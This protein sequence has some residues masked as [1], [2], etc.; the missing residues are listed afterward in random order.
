MK[1]SFRWK[2]LFV[3]L[4][5]VS[6]IVFCTSLLADG[7]VGVKIF[8][9]KKDRST[10]LKSDIEQVVDAVEKSFCN[11]GFNCLDRGAG[12][13]AMLEEVKLGQQGVLNEAIKLGKARQAQFAL[14]VIVDRLSS[15]SF[16]LTT[17]LIHLESAQIIPIS[18]S[19]RKP[20]IDELFDYASNTLGRVV[21]VQRKTE[22]LRVENKLSLYYFC[23]RI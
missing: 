21:L 15:G 4:F 19:E 1:F 5:V 9:V 14:V 23:N 22:F 8:P 20:T 12:M 11:L 16:T 3:T 10:I 18:D 2:K 17:K 13:S 7:Q 6:Q